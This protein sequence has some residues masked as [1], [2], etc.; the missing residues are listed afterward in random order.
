MAV[1]PEERTALCTPSV[2]R[3]AAKGSPLPK[4]FPS[5]MVKH[6]PLQISQGSPCK[7]AKHSSLHSAMHFSG[8]EQSGPPWPV[9]HTHCPA[10]QMPLPSQLRGQSRKAQPGPEKPGGHFASLQSIPVNKSLQAHS[11]LKHS[12]L[13]EQSFGHAG[14]V[15]YKAC[16]LQSGRAHPNSQVHSAAEFGEENPHSPWPEQSLMHDGCLQAGPFQP[17]WQ[18]QT[19]SL[20]MPWSPQS[21]GQTWSVQT[22]S[23]SVSGPL[24]QPA[25]Q[26]Q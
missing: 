8:I 10:K 3:R 11:P 20:H 23:P 9:S 25:A 15:A 16:V 13:P 24:P 21:T 18:M 12:P 6:R 19:L 14:I 17:S 26:T 2:E 7:L 4:D 1:W 5:R 22:F